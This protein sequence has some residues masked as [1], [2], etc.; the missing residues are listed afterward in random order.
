MHH[1]EANTGK[2]MT[3]E[4]FE[5]MRRLKVAVAGDVM[6]DTYWWGSA[7]RI[8]PEAPVPVVTL[9]RTEYRIGGAANVA[10]NALALAD[11]VSLLSVIGDD[12]EGE[13][14]LK[15]LNK[16]GIETSGINISKQRKTTNKTRVISRNQQMIRLDHETTS[17]LS[18]AE[19][20]EFIETCRNYIY[21]E[22]PDVFIF[23]DYNKGILTPGVISELLQ[24]CKDGNIF[25]AVD[26]KQKNFFAYQ[27]VHLFKPNLK[28]VREGLRYH[29]NE[30]NLESLNEM[31]HL[32]HN[33]LSHQMSLITLSEKGVFCSQENG[34][35]FLLPTF[36]RDIADVSGA[37]D[38]VIAVASLVYSA[39]K[40]LR[41]MAA[42][43]NLA[44]GL[45]CEEVGTVPVSR[46]RLMSE[47]VRQ[48][49]PS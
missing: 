40:N 34:D 29:N 28:E 25:T 27:G 17:D 45:V 6:L 14:L 3:A 43:A 23:E 5:K 36:K 16:K 41:L 48:H 35:S 37:G 19:E 33:H 30:V 15:E 11:K 46:D 44:G 39:T 8:S 7:E 42:I 2:M 21:A 18:E 32:L 12:Q 47:C 20:K 9:D 1:I 26:P 31:H 49:I 13:L 4:L 24:I 10:L 22:K 38:T